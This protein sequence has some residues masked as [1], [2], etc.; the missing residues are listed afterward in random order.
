VTVG[1]HSPLPPAETGVA[2][3][4]SALLAGLRRYGAVRA[5]PGAADVN[6]YHLGN[7]P[8][9]REIYRR[10]LARPGVV[11]LHDA[12]L[13]HFFLGG[14]DRAGYVE[15]FVYNYGEWH[16]GLAEELWAA[17][18]QSAAGERYFR[19]PMLRRIAETSRAVIVHNPAAA[20]MVLSHAPQAR[21]H[22]IPHLFAP[23][24]E[25]TAAEVQR[26]RARL[27]ISAGTTIFSILGYLRE[28]KRLPVVL[29]AFD[30]IR[31]L[32]L[33]AVL[34]VAGRFISPDLERAVAPFMNRPDVRYFG[35]TGE[36]TFWLLARAADACL[37]L[38][39]PAAGETSG[40]TIRLMGMGKPVAVTD[41][42]EVSRFPA[43]ACLRVEYGMAEKDELVQYMMMLARS[44]GTAREIGRLAAAHIRERHS[45]DA[46]ASSYWGVL[47]ACRN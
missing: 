21:V 27:G 22:E 6:L 34:L 29:K 24:P 8:L 5:G 32:G 20:R 25:V 44:R 3:Y 26:L 7:N 11:V 14:M 17:R 15:E 33:D 43:G 23:P 9:H 45:L 18:S 31:R 10:A 12:V 42:E 38:R 40:I 47:C 28:S 37:N 16:R 35:A 1:F 13:Q 19:Y 39:Y 2:G 41:S 30:E 46:V 36:R 4:A